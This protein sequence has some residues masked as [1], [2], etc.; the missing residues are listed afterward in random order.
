MVLHTKLVKIGNSLGIRIPKVLLAQHGLQGEVELDSTADGL[1]IR[2]PSHPRAGWA[3]AMAA[4][5]VEIDAETVEDWPVTKL[6]EA[7]WQW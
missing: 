3:E 7:E 4:H 5:Q 1:V 6:Y 2:R